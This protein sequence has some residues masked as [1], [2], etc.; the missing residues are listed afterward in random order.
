LIPGSLLYAPAAGAKDLATF[1]VCGAKGCASVTGRSILRALLLGIRSQREAARASTPSPVPFLRFEY[2]A[3]GDDG[4]KP[5]F[6][7]YY[8][9]SR[10]V[11]EVRTGP[12]SWTWIRPDLAQTVFR[13]VSKSVRP[14]PAPLISAVTI[15]GR[16]IQ[17]PAF[18]LRLFTLQAKPHAFPAQPDWTLIVVKTTA[19]SPWSTTA[20]TLEYSRSTNILWRGNEFVQVP[21]PIAS[22]LEAP[23]AAGRPR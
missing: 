10:G 17:D 21:S 23:A 2:W 7:Q 22:R 8:V 9:P 20:A 14:F 3:R 12:R 18:Y 11:L 1:N 6:V 19:P 16:P 15:G 4:H 5:S 13:R